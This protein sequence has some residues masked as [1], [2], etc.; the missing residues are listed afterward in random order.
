MVLVATYKI[1]QIKTLMNN[2]KTNP[3][4]R[5]LMVIAWNVGELDQMVLPPCHYGFQVYTRELS[6][7]RGMSIGKFENNYETGI[8]YNES[9]IPNFDDN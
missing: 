9:N 1:D 8:E 2:L 7:E 6:E 5:R 4:S 3:D